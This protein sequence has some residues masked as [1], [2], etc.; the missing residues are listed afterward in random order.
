MTVSMTTRKWLDLYDLLL[1][2]M[3]EFL[4][5]PKRFY[6]H[7]GINPNEEGAAPL[8]QKLDM[9]QYKDL[10]ASW[11]R[12]QRAIEFFGLDMSE[13]LTIAPLPQE[14]ATKKWQ[15]NPWLEVFR[16]T[17]MA[18]GVPFKG[19]DALTAFGFIN[20]YIQQCETLDPSKK[21]REMLEAQGI[22]KENFD[23]MLA[24]TSIANPWND[25]SAPLV[26]QSIITKPPNLN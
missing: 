23:V 22:T 4:A 5:D 9:E 12:V 25:P 13:E 20:F 14:M 3:V 11:K 1:D 6:Q 10:R 2:R 18:H 15:A 8:P 19:R 7:L 21:V 16:P 24:G 17:D 26:Q